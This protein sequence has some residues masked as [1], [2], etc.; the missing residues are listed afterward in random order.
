[1]AYS[2]IE[3]LEVV[4]AGFL[5]EK[6]YCDLFGFSGLHYG[7]VGF[8]GTIYKVIKVIFVYGVVSHPGIEFSAGFDSSDVEVES[9]KLVGGEVEGVDPIDTSDFAMCSKF[10]FICSPSLPTVTAM[11]W[12][13][14]SV[15]VTR[16]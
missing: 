10:F 3:R 14:V 15:S 4:I 5:L 7:V 6:I 8:A 11:V 2:T 1:M 9:F 16:K 13:S 12:H